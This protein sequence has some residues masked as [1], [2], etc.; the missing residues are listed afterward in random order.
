MKYKILLPVI[1]TIS[2][3]A[4]II[5]GSYYTRNAEVK[6]TSIS[7]PRA[8]N[9]L[10]GLLEVIN[11]LYV[12]TVNLKELIE[13]TIPTVLDDLDPHSSYIRAEDLENANEELEGHFS[14]IG[15][16]FNIQNDTITVVNV[17]SGGP[18]EKV[19]VM[20]GDRIV[21]IND[22]LFV[23]KEVTNE[24]VMKQLRGPKGTEVKI[25]VRRTTAESIIPIKIIRGD[26]PLTSVDASY[27][28]EE[29]VGFIRISKFGAST[30]NEFITALAKLSSQGCDRFIIDLRGNLGGYMEAAINMINEFLPAK[31]L[32]VYT[33]GKSVP[34]NEAFSNGAGAFQQS[35]VVVLLDEWSASASEIFAGAIQDNDRGLIIGRRSFGKGLVQ[36]QLPFNDGSAIRLT[37]ARYY[38]PSGRSI[39]KKYE[40]GKG[41]EYD[42]DLYERY[43]RGEFFSKD[44]IKQV[45]STEYF[46]VGGRVVYGGG[47]IMP[48]IFT[49]RDTVAFTP[50]FNRVVNFSILYQFCF[51]YA[52]KNR[53]AIAALPD[54]K[55]V[56]AY[57]DKKNVLNEFIA[58]A[59]S[60]GVKPN[61]ADIA[62]SRVLLTDQIYAYIARNAKDDEA[63]FRLFF[64][65]D[66]T[67]L[68]AVKEIKQLGP[69]VSQY[70]SN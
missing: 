17:I 49:P 40:P 6:G 35:P 57:L 38:T 5:I 51:Q 11:Q 46:T 70:S 12:D 53:A 24:K 23:G 22:T 18:A 64:K 67:V 1:I 48:D 8:S 32:I 26:I 21:E 13:K 44:S 36:Q 4:G 19:G 52:D 30:Y 43:Q 3:A 14:G 9:K 65:H 58:Y 37:I 25:G 16:Q 56:E 2:I 41:G 33:E 63:F 42:L 68:R 34:R 50:Y 27:M 15:V 20:P 62:K 66:E 55:A 61:H 10:S 7:I 29:G 59:E 54:T 28:I 60:K 39:Q 69:S 31:Q 45:D 47:G